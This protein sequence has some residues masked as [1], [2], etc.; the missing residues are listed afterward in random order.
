M[1]L[2]FAK[3]GQ[4]LMAGF[5]DG[6]IQVW[7]L[8]GSNG[9]LTFQ[10]HNRQVD[11]LALLPDGR[12][13]VSAGTDV[14]FWDLTSQRELIRFQPRSTTFLG[15][16]ISPDGRRL[17]VGAVDGLISIWDLVSRHEV[18]TLK[19]HERSVHDVAFLSD[20]N[21]LVS[22]GQEQVRVWRAASFEETDR[23]ALKQ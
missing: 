17:A 9:E 1:S 11:G 4:R 13:L 15:C 2:A 12:T 19:G 5:D 20:G 23:E 10:R 18:A 3:D 16:S 22:V 14:R 21:T 7:D 8:S 6:L